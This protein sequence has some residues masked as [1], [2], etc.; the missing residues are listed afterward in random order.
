[1]FGVI[2]WSDPAASSAVIWCEE[3]SSLAYYDAQRFNQTPPRGFFDTGD[4][5]EFDLVTADSG[6]MA[7]N[8]RTIVLSKP[9]VN[10]LTD[11]ATLGKISEDAPQGA[12]IIRLSDH[13][14]RKR[15]A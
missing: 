15:P 1:M 6:W 8:A 10:S 11:P 4:F 13:A 2:I 14:L 7:V 9:V 5:V 12:Q 3:K